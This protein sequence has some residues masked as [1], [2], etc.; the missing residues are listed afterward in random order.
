MK[1]PGWMRATPAL[2]AVVV[3]A[4]LATPETVAPMNR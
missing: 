4:T 1:L 3:I 2:S